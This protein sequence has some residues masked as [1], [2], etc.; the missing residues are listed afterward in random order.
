[1]VNSR[2][3]TTGEQIEIRRCRLGL[4]RR[5]VAQLA[6]RSEE[7][8]RN[9]EH[10]HTILDSIR[11]TY[12]LAEILRFDNPMELIGWPTSGRSA[13][14]ER[15]LQLTTLDRAIMDNQSSQ[16]FAVDATPSLESVRFE[17]DECWAIWMS[18]NCRYT[19]LA[20]L[21]PAVLVAARSIAQLHA[22]TRA[23]RRRRLTE[24]WSTP[25]T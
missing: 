3:L 18:S 10:G 11:V 4:S 7:W 14:P 9:V 2:T 12:R 20:G 22:P 8:L 23:G 6:G 17:L 16:A 19:R 25:T 13:A 1:M 15:D 24:P 5:I 21:L